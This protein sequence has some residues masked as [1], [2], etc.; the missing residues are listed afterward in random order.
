METK[1]TNKRLRMAAT[2]AVLIIPVMNAGALPGPGGLTQ[3]V[4][5]PGEAI[6]EST[7]LLD[8]LG[9]VGTPGALG[10][11]LFESY[12]GLGL[13]C[14]DNNGHPSYNY[15]APHEY[16]YIFGGP[17]GYCVDAD[18]DSGSIHVRGVNSCG[19]GSAQVGA[20]VNV[21]ASGSYD[22]LMH[23]YLE[24]ARVNRG[25]V[26]VNV[27]ICDDSCTWYNIW[28]TDE[29]C[30]TYQGWIHIGGTVELDRGEDYVFVIDVTAVRYSTEMFRRASIEGEFHTMSLEYVGLAL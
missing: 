8:A 16:E 7:G 2:L 4:P 30:E 20:R 5:V 21:E 6:F 12:D 18:K 15:C 26:S 13:G 10:A 25:E 11:G 9:D 19:G 28:D 27:G 1:Q 17:Q 3:P 24:H 29:C 14:G 23:F 22:L